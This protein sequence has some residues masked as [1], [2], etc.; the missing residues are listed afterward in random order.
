MDSFG[1]CMQYDVKHVDLQSMSVVQEPLMIPLIVA[2]SGRELFVRTLPDNLDEFLVFSK[3][4]AI[5]IEKF[6][7]IVNLR[8]SHWYSSSFKSLDKLC[9][10][11]HQA[12]SLVHR[13]EKINNADSTKLDM[14][15]N[16]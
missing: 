10:C 16:P 5:N 15:E 4:I 14:V 2:S 8:P 3:P 12:A 13:A 6:K 11:Y 7:Q 1:I 9:L